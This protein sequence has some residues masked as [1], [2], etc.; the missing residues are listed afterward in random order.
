MIVLLDLR[1][2]ESG[3]NVSKFGAS[4]SKD[5]PS[6]TEVVEDVG[7]APALVD[8]SN[9]SE[10][11]YFIEDD[12]INAGINVNSSTPLSDGLPIHQEQP[13]V[14]NETPR[15]AR[16]PAKTAKKLLEE[17]VKEQ[18]KFYKS[19]TNLLEVQNKLMRK[20]NEE[21]RL[22]TDEMRKKRRIKEK[23]L[24]LFKNNIAFKQKN[25]IENTK[26]KLEKIDLKRRELELKEAQLNQTEL[27]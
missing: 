15:Q 4:T 11:E 8:C 22:Q 6:S 14:Q 20:Q 27:N 23:K 24:D 7:A 5:L 10:V 1:T 16:V 21:L 26:I 9:E 2:S 19:F 3:L 18:K 25:S 13:E 17:Q 12:E